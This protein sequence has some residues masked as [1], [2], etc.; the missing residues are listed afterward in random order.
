MSIRVLIADDHSVVRQ[1]LRMFLALD[2]DIDIVGEACDGVQAL[3]L[4]HE[5]RPDVVLMD[6]LMPEMDGIQATARV[7]AEL[8][9]TEVIA[10]TSVLEDS[11]VVNAIRAGAIG[12]LLK[13][14]EADVLVKAIKAAAEGQVQLSPQAAARLIEDAQALM[15]SYLAV[16]FAVPVRRPDGRCPPAVAVRAVNLAVYFLRLGRDSVTPDARAQYEDDVRWLTEVVAGRAALG[17]EDCPSES[18]G[19]PRVRSET[20]PRLFGRREPL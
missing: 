9:D 5:L 7:R 15:D 19:A 12:Y 11:S 6:L 1:G 2:P 13:D 3:E 8:P 14:T 10:L 17:I 4:A 18:V 20:C 16:R